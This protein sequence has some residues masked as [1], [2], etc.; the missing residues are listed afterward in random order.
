MSMRITLSHE[1]RRCYCEKCG[2]EFW[3]RPWRYK[4]G[5][6]W[7]KQCPKCRKHWC[8]AYFEDGEK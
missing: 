1:P 7:P 8:I 4:D 5:H 6:E 3:N 2:Y